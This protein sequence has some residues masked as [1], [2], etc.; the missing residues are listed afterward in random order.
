MLRLST[1]AILALPV[2]TQAIP[3]PLSNRD[4][5]CTAGTLQCCAAVKSAGLIA[6]LLGSV[7]IVGVSCNAVST[8]VHDPTGVCS[9]QL[10]LAC[11][12]GPS[13]LDITL[14]CTPVNA[15]A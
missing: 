4:L 7:G 14:G 6:G 5:R 11:C 12:T 1:F 13:L 2:L 9:G 3:N 8:S 10:E 15:I